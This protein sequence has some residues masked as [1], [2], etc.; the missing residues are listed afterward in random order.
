MVAMGNRLVATAGAMFVIRIVASTLVLRCANIRISV[1]HFNHM[2]IDMI[3]MGVVQ[4]TIMQVI[5]VAVMR[6]LRVTAIGAVL[7]RVVL[8]GIA[9]HRSLLQ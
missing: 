3:G 6:N 8:M 7:V 9:A 1:R 5:D 2:L 4:M